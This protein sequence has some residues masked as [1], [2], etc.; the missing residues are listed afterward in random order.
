MDARKLG[1]WVI[2]PVLAVCVL[3]SAAAATDYWVDALNGD[4]QNGNGGRTAPWQTI[5]F[6]LTKLAAN[7]TLHVMPGLYD[8]TG[9]GE[10]FPLQLPAGVVVEGVSA[11]DCIVDGEGN[12]AR[13]IEMNSQTRVRY[14]TVKGATAGWWNAAIADWTGHNDWQVVGCII[15]S[16]NARG[17]HVWDKNSNV[18]IADNFFAN[19]YNDNVSVFASTNVDI[20]NNTFDGTTQK[21]LKA[22]IITGNNNVPSS[23]RIYNNS[24][25]NMTQ[26]GID[27][28]AASA[29]LVTLDNNNLWANV[30]NYGATLTPGPNDV[31]VDPQFVNLASSNLHLAATSPLVDRGS[32]TLASTSDIDQTPRPQGQGVDIGA[33]EIVYEPTPK[34]LSDFHI[35]KRPVPGAS[36]DFVLLGKPQSAG[37]FALSLLQQNPPISM[38]VGQLHLNLAVLLLYMPVGFDARGVGQF[39]FP[40]PNVAGLVG[41]DVYAQGFSGTWLTR[42]EAIF[43]R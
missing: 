4:D 40:I 15:D 25:T 8:G 5:T 11:R 12:P 27:A 19:V 16:P 24:I 23:G 37:A 13:V 29:A 21:S 7:D 30:A 22:I 1:R 18:V 34:A 17:I 43:I 14:L 20:V 38:P 36:I 6:S 39:S 26:F 35:W 42:Y 3:A 2:L 33:D 10:T 41:L 31:S 28:D 32:R 9:N